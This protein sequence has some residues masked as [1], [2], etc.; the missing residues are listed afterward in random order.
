[1]ARVSTNSVK[2]T[3]YFQ[4]TFKNVN[5]ICVLNYDTESIFVTHKDVIFEVPGASIVNRVSVP[6]IPFIINGLGN[7]IDEVKIEITFPNL[8]GNAVVNSSQF[9]KC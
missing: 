7:E 4:Q 3:K 1:M 6:S 8:I 9:I 2:V 5:E